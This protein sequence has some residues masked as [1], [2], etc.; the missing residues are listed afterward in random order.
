MS[1]G[2]YI[3]SL[4]IVAKFTRAYS[5]AVKAA[6]AYD[7]HVSWLDYITCIFEALQVLDEGDLDSIVKVSKGL[8]KK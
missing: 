4:K 8:K 5:K 2:G 1:I 3:A 7:G 6:Q